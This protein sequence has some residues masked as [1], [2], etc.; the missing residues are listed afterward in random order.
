MSPFIDIYQKMFK[1]YFLNFVVHDYFSTDVKEYIYISV[2]FF[3]H[4][5]TAKTATN[6]TRNR[7]KK[8]CHL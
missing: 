8:M 4:F 5:E 6:V 7:A 2:N 3:K 1:I